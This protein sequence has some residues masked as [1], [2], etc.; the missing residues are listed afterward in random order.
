M[1]DLGESRRNGPG[2]SAGGRAEALWLPRK[3][4]AKRYWQRRGLGRPGCVMVLMVAT[5]VMLIWFL[6]VTV[7]PS[8]RTMA[9]LEVSGLVTEILARHLRDSLQNRVS[10]RDLIYIEKDDSGRIVFMQANTDEVTRVEAETLLCVQQAL[11]EIDGI[12]M[13]LPLGQALG[14]SLLA[15][16]GPSIPVTLKAMGM[17]SAR[18][19]D[20]F[21]SR[22]INNVRHSIYIETEANVR[23]VIPLLPSVIKVKVTM[24]LTEA[25]IA[26]E[27]PRAYLNWGI[28]EK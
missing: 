3:S 14:S 10:Y 22:G 11:G 1:V 6:E 16:I 17:A 2:L 7:A 4:G 8:L 28:G 26:G 27:V 5:A 9:E 12:K 25:I 13:E 23:V 20:T 15:N 18:V 19:R 24:P 21:E